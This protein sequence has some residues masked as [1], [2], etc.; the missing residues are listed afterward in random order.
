MHLDAFSAVAVIAASAAFLV[1]LL[2][3]LGQSAVVAYLL[4]GIVFGPSGMD[5]VP[6]DESVQHLSEIG[7]IFLLFFIGLEFHIDAL[8]RTAGL[9]FGGTATQILFCGVPVYLAGHFSGL[10]WKENLVLG[11]C[12]ALSST[13]IVVKA[14]EDRKEADSPAAQSSLSILIG[15]DFVAL[16]A[17]AALPAILG[18][19][20]GNGGWNLMIMAG[21]LPILYFVAHKFLPI[22]FRRAAVSQNQ[23]AFALCSLGACLLVAVAAYQLKATYSLGAF[24]GGL[25]FAGTPYAH[26]IRAD[27][28]AFRN[29]AIGFFFFTV[30]SQLDLTYAAA[31]GP[32]VL[33]ALAA[34]LAVKVIGA[35]FAFR[36]FGSPWSVAAAAGLALSQVGEFAFVLA[37]EATK[38]G[39]IGDDRRQL[40]LTVAVL[41]ML[42][43]PALIARANVFGRKVAGVLGM[44]IRSPKSG[45]RPPLPSVD[46]EESPTGTETVRAL[47]VG[48]G[49]VGRV[50]CKILIRFGVSPCVIDLQLDTVKKLHA[51]NREAIY[52][53]A[54]KREVLEAAGVAQA[55]YLIITLPDLASRAPIILSAK[56]I[57]PQIT[58]I[59][60]ARY[61]TERGALETSG[62]DHISYEEAEVAAELARLLLNQLGARDDLLQNEV[63]RLRTEIA[64]RTGF[65]QV[66][67]RPDAAPAGQTE[68]WSAAQ[69]EAALKK[70]RNSGPP[71]S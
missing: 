69:I 5:V 15:Q 48:Y 2:Q 63:R 67:R 20:G 8:K 47:V 1:W 38:G 14:F 52:G 59:S 33:G 45:A 53:D 31:N 65:T 12:T 11:L 29:L 10:S 54:G 46:G 25:V 23:E 21:S 3:K 68:I 39:A 19:G 34:L 58:I 28:A 51:I 32:L 35:T 9:V 16:A 4:L 7:V 71:Q 61:L 40:L 60:R 56:A 70:R 13:A 64:V 24:L 66:F 36:L 18:S 55:K 6:N 49:P 44:D 50:L 62:A 17:I 41:S 22:V 43:A 57:N 42:V 30:G 26:Q 37:A 27:L